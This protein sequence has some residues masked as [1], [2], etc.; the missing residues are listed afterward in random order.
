MAESYVWRKASRL[1]WQS[2]GFPPNEAIGVGCLQRIA[3]SL[4]LICDH[5]D[6]INTSLDPHLK[7]ER[8]DTRKK[9]DDWE[10]RRKARFEARS[11]AAERWK[12]ELP[13]LIREKCRYKVY[14][15]AKRASEYLSPE[16]MA[17]CSWANRD[18]WFDNIHPL[19]LWTRLR[20]EIEQ[21]EMQAKAGK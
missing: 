15:I 1:D 13:A 21:A 5:L 2:N 6:G 17:S 16:E 18:D 7:K 4:E 20:A 11:Q 19:K 12:L 14:R 8:D 3:D 10:V 9:H